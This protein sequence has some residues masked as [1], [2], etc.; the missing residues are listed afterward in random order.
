MEIVLNPVRTN[1]VLIALLVALS[2]AAPSTGP[3]TEP[4]TPV[5]RW[6]K[7][8]ADDD[9][10]VRDAAREQ[11]MNLDREGLRELKRAVERNRP[12]APAQAL[13]LRDIVTHVFLA[14]LPYARAEGGAF[15]GV[16]MGPQPSGDGITVVARIPGFAAY[17]ALRDGDVIVAIQ[18]WPEPLDDTAKFG[19]KIAEW[20][21]GDTIHLKVRRGGRILT[22]PLTLS[23]RPQEAQNAEAMRAEQMPAADEYWQQNFAPL[24]EQTASS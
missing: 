19:R 8:L 7:Q 17:R 21:G 20:R 4:A 1:V 22:V 18:E 2:G 3:S 5:A 13:A 12:L 16:K 15:V 6:L 10:D 14:S 23:P 11:L 24:L 9:P